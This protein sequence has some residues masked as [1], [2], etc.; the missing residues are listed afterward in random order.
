MF[1]SSY[2]VV[3][4]MANKRNQKFLRLY[5]GTYAESGADGIFLYDFDSVG[6]T[7]TYRSKFKAGANP[8]FLALS[9][10]GRFLYAVNETSEFQGNPGG[11]VSAFAI[12]PVSGSLTFLN[13]QPSHGSVPCHLSLDRSERFLF[14]ANYLSG[15][16]AVYPL[17]AGGRIGAVSQCV[18][19]K[20]ENPESMPRAHFIS[21]TADNRFALSCDLGAGKV[22]IYKWDL[23]NGKLVEHSEAVL[24]PGAG[25][26]HLDFHPSGRFVYVINE[27]DS[28]MAFFSYAVETGVMTHRQTLSTLPDGYKGSNTC[29]EVCVHPNGRYVYGSNRGHDSVVIFAVDEAGGKLRL[30]GHES[31]RGKVP[32]HMVFDPGGSYLLVANQDSDS[33]VVF[34]VDAETGRLQFLH[35]ISVPKPV[36]VIFD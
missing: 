18:Q 33:V 15:T 5:I 9:K 27:L 20:G 13:H 25:P 8:S 7:L 29:A 2:G 21:V 4:G 23:P 6:G 31:T 10:S 17:E 35:Q 26:R 28:T 12:E 24:A 14:A 16:V 32:R 1:V 11:A 19:Q 36:C 22:F 30:I 34:R 3:V